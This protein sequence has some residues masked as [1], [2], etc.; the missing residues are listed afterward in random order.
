MRILRRTLA[1]TVLYVLSTSFSNLHAV[2]SSKYSHCFTA[3]ARTASNRTV[4]RVCEAKPKAIQQNCAHTFSSFTAALTEQ[5]FLSVRYDSL[6]QRA[7][8]Y[9][10]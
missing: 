7:C 2:R 3:A 8:N 10:E 4:Q 6:E 5:D 1:H 9:M